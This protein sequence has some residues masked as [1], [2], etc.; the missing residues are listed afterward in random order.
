LPEAVGIKEVHDSTWLVSFMDC[1]LGHF[2]LDTG[3]LELLDNPFVP[4]LLPM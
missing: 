4:R 1:D 3:M 2:D